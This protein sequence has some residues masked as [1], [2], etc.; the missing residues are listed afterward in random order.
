MPLVLRLL[1][2]V[3]SLP[4]F[5]VTFLAIRSEVRTRRMLR[6]LEDEERAAIALEREQAD[7]AA[8][9]QPICSRCRLRPT[10]GLKGTMCAW[11][12]I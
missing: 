1:I 3:F 5:L 11:C 8:S 9:G 10:E 12:G 7:A 4:V 6:K 2:C